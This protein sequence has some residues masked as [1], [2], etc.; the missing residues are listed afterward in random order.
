MNNEI[1]EILDY[2]KKE[3]DKFEESKTYLMETY[4]YREQDIE[5]I[6]Q[7]KKYVYFKKLLDY[8]T[9]L[10][11]TKANM[12]QE[13]QELYLIKD[14]LQEENKKLEEDNYELQKYINE[15]EGFVKDENRELGLRIDEAVE[16]NNKNIHSQTLNNILQ[17]DDNE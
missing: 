13:L 3:V 1:K 17:G 4:N 12:E 6:E 11:E 8:I 5:N 7:H 10:Q 14:N 2:L 15:E 16:Y 9:N